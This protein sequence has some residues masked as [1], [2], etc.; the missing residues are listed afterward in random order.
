M[1]GVTLDTLGKSFREDEWPASPPSQDYVGIFLFRF[2]RRGWVTF[3]RSVNIKEICWNLQNIRVSAG[4]GT[5]EEEKVG[6]CMLRTVSFLCSLTAPSIQSLFHP[7]CLL[8][9]TAC[10]CLWVWP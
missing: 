7:F 10:S 9:W 3:D 6:P 4:S 8:T 1:G 2:F 5:V